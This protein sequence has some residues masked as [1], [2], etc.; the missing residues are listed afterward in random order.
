MANESAQLIVQLEGQV[1][2]T[3]TLTPGVLTIGRM[4][5]NGLA[6]PHPQ[7][8]RRHAE[9]RLEETGALL[10]D[11]ESR[12]G[13]FVG[14]TRLLPNRPQ[15]LPAG[16]VFRIGPFVLT[17]RLGSVAAPE[18]PAPEEPAPAEAPAALEEP[19]PEPLVP[20]AA[21]PPLAPPRPRLPVPPLP[22]RRSRYL[23]DLPV[24]Y[25]DNDFLGRYLMLFETIWEPLEQ[26]QDAIAMYFDP[27]TCP[28]AFLPWLAAWLGIAINPYWPE[29][30]LRHLVTEAT[31]L[32][33]WR[34]TRYGLARLIEVC[35]GL[36]PE[37]ADDPADPFVIHVTV[38]LPTDSDIDRALLDELIRAHKPAHIGYILAIR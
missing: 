37:I 7:V 30:R 31:D 18:E 27:R 11:L 15:L 17:Y 13:T 32:Y 9:L 4:P 6:L 21:A 1:I 34:G 38:T 16:A 29:A 35:T 8:E 2:Q 14:E 33:R 28:A 19:A 5:D 23:A 3:L 36:T 20:V 22:G 26:R 24:I 25:H 10:T 12:S